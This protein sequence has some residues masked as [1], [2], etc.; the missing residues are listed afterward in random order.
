[1]NIMQQ[2]HSTLMMDFKKGAGMKR[3]FNT[4][5]YHAVDKY[6]VDNG[7]T[8]RELALIVGISDV[9]L[10]RCLT[11]ERNISLPVFMKMCKAFNLSYDE[12]WE[13]YNAYIFSNGKENE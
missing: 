4:E 12:I 11:C 10:S 13:L 6:C 8:H 9:M 3:R 5:F 2:W 1:M 7:I